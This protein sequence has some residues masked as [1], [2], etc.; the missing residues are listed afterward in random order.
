MIDRIGMT[1]IGVGTWIGLF[2]LLSLIPF[3]ILY[4]IRPKPKEVVIP[5]LMFLGQSSEFRSKGGFFRKAVNDKVLLLQMLILFLIS[6]FFAAP[7]L[8]LGNV[9]G[10]SVVMVLDTSASMSSPERF[11]MLKETAL[12]NLG[13][14]NT[15]ILVGSK[16]SMI[17]N[18][19]DRNSAE[20]E[21][22]VMIAMDSRSAI[23]ES[24][25]FAKEKL[26]EI[27]GEKAVVIISDFLDTENGDVESAIESLKSTG[28]PLKIVSVETTDK[29]NV[30]IVSLVLRKTESQAIVKNFCCDAKDVQIDYGGITKSVNI[31]VG[32][33][34]TYDF[35]MPKGK[36]ELKLLNDDVV[37]SDNIAYLNNQE[38]KKAKVVIISNGESKYLEA[39]LSASSGIDLDIKTPGNV[40]SNYDLYILDHAG[41]IPS[42]LSKMLNDEL[43]NGKSVVLIAEKGVTGDYGVFDFKVESDYV[44]GSTKEVQDARFLDNVDFGRQSG[45]QRVDCVDCEGVFVAIDQSPVVM[46]HPK[47]RGLVG[48]YGLGEEGGFQNKPD[49]PIFWTRF[50]QH[51]AGVRDLSGMNLKTGSS[52]VFGEEI[53]YGTPSGKNGKG[54]IV[55]LNEAGFYEI[56]GLDY[57]ANLLSEKESALEQKEEVGSEENESDIF[58][59]SELVKK[60]IWKELILAAFILLLIEWWIMARRLRRNKYNV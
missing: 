41:N 1:L 12:D 9:G 52:V 27:S 60:S 6:L 28:V 54:K 51:L 50:A 14:R 42:V 26:E 40:R 57:S 3:L 45:I 31:P 15:I 44:G 48:Y 47:G 34:Y 5:S 38:D 4:F 20:K 2:G 36:S 46:V 29:N 19:A 43:E 23:S 10:G 58:G 8:M 53:K 13:G 32:G 16:P 17:L 25:T 55:V 56:N 49:Y 35:E 11:D 21:L 33:T 22:R 24:L 30:G 59:E 37:L 7:Y 18:D 39:A